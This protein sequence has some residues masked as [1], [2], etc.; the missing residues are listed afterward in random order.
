MT[1]RFAQP[2]SLL[3]LTLFES[4]SSRVMAR[5]GP[6]GHDPIRALI[7]LQNRSFLFL[8]FFESVYPL[9][10]ALDSIVMSIREHILVL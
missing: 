6:I 3:F 7:V 1:I 4:A 5:G 9:V 8:T 10:M 2:F